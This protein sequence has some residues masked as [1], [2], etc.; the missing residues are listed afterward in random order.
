[1]YHVLTYFLAKLF[2]AF[3][4]LGQYERCSL[5]HWT[6]LGYLKLHINTCSFSRLFTHAVKGFSTK[7]T[8]GFCS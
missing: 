7:R 8:A 4:Q 6:I 3:C 5:M 1:M 2:A